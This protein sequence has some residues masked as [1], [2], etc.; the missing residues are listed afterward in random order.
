M[1]YSVSNCTFDKSLVGLVHSVASF[2]GRSLVSSGQFPPLVC[3]NEDIL[4]NF[5]RLM[6]SF[7]S[8]LLLIQQVFIDTSLI[9]DLGYNSKQFHSPYF[10]RINGLV[11][12]GG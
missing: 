4:Q 12:H 3:V 7:F 1:F 11:G 5:E 10:Y 6:T 8:T 9:P 2:M